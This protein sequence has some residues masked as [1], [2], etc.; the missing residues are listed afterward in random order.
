MKN[1]IAALVSVA[2]LVLGVGAGVAIAAKTG[3]PGI[4]ALRGKSATDAAAAALVQAEILAGTGTWERIAVARAYYLSGNKS[5]GQELIDRVMA[6]KTDH[7]DWQRIGVLYAEAAETDKAVM[8]FERA[9]AADPKDDTGQS[10]IGAWYIRMGRREQG[11]AL[12]AK[13]F[14][15]SPDEVGHY[16]RAA[17]A[18]LNLPPH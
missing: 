5:K 9:L 12:F 2:C 17:E 4:E 6:G 3:G 15:R 1:S 8:Y 10:E 13:A 16:L 18:Y 11:E 7:N 14:A